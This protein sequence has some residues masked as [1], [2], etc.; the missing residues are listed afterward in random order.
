MKTFVHLSRSILLRMWNAW[1]KIWVQNLNTHS[2]SSNFIRKSCSLWDNVKR[3]IEELCRPQM[4][5]WRMRTACCIPKDT[6]T[7]S[8]YVILIAFY[9]NNGCKNVL[10][11]CNDFVFRK[12]KT[13]VLI[14]IWIQR[15]S[16]GI[17]APKVKLYEFICHVLFS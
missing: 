16:A 14:K 9:C 1:Y 12:E 17:N 13:V 11:R 6:N 8:A 7:Q 5:T 15:E 4:T 3:N 2:M 10:L